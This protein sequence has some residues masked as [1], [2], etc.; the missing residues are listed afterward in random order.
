MIYWVYIVQGSDGQLYCGIS[1]NTDRRI[2]QH[3]SGKGAKWARGRLPVKLV[4]EEA[5]GSKS[6]A[7]KREAEIKRMSL[8]AKKKLIGVL[9]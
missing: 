7:L 9:S 8:T 3:N 5:A 1:T 2:A 4:Y 6:A